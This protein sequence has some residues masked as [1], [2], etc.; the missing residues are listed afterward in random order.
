MLT[1]IGLRRSHVWVRERDLLRLASVFSGF[2]ANLTYIRMHAWFL[3]QSMISGLLIEGL[4]KIKV[5][6]PSAF[7]DAAVD[8]VGHCWHVCGQGLPNI[9]NKVYLT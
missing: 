9:N 5:H 7:T 6:S 2:H 4:L 1:N 8:V 3:M